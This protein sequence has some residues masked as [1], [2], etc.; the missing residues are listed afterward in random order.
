VVVA[1]E[2][3]YRA[4]ALLE[5]TRSQSLPTLSLNGS[6]TRLDHDRVLG[7]SVILPKDQVNANLFLSVPL[8][9]TRGWVQW[10]HARDNVNVARWSADEVR[11]QLAISVGR[12][13]LGILVQK[14]VI[15]V[16]LRAKTAA[17]AH[18]DYANQR[19]T[20][21]YGSRLD[22]VRAEQEVATDA[23]QVERAQL[24][25]VRLQEALGVL[26]GAD[27]PLDAAD[28]ELALGPPPGSTDEAMKDAR[29]LRADVK[30]AAGRLDAAR[31][32]T[33][34]NWADYVPTLFGTFEPFLQHPITSTLPSEG[35]QA[36]ILLSW[37]IYDGGLRYGQSKERKAL[38]REA[39][40]QLQGTQRQALSDVRAAEEEVRRSVAALAL[41]QEAAKNA[42]EAQDLTALGYRAG[43][44]T[45]IEVIDAERA[46]RDAA[47]AVAVAEDSLR[48]GQLD[49]LIASGRFGR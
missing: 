37:Q 46:A 5:Q 31:H 15:E 43:A 24:D 32:L 27:A 13:Y 14:R 7:G 45:N 18:Y 16:N 42:L 28:E 44:T 11:R 25:L 34:D 36:Q 9:Q 41:A 26:S 2:E 23:A 1:G 17:Q 40:A 6:Y 12:T 39:E 3:I 10:S 30:L 4:R 35:W 49:L 47:T 22:R 19:F 33:R 38:T 21:G 8:V 29:S 20:A 48:Q